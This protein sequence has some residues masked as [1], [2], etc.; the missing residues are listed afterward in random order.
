MILQ[1]KKSHQ[2]LS[3]SAYLDNHPIPA[4]IILDNETLDKQIQRCDICRVILYSHWWNIKWQSC[5]TIVLYCYTHFNICDMTC[6]Y[7]QFFNQCQIPR[8]TF[9]NIHLPT[10]GSHSLY[11][12]PHINPFAPEGN[13]RS[14]YSNPNHKLIHWA[15]PV[16]LV[17]GECQSTPVMIG[18]HWFR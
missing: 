15:I 7:Y 16:N 18:R 14:E 13:F 17:W 8:R 3:D 10:H 2:M 1:Q 4:K 12:M 9:T 6:N 5:S 11:I